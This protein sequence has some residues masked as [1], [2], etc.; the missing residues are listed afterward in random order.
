M[1][2]RMTDR[3]LLEAAAKAAGYDI[4]FWSDKAAHKKP[5]HGSWNPLADDGDALR[6]AMKLKLNIAQGDYSVNV[7]DE[8][9]VDESALV[10]S[11]EVRGEVLRRT[12]V[13]AAAAIRS[14]G[15]GLVP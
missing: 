2:T 10:R 13:R 5:P 3:D 11:E 6:L 14:D 15:E 7:N 4:Y 1:D 9:E 8:Y 12:I